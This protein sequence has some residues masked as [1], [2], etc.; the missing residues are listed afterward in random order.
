MP[1]A[2][3]GQARGMRQDQNNSFEMLQ[4]DLGGEGKGCFSL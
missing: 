1:R 4:G 3:T 2:R